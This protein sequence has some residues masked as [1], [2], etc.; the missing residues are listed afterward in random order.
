M[1]PF[2]VRTSPLFLWVTL[3]TSAGCDS[4]DILQRRGPAGVQHHRP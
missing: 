2:C 1:H 4:N 3:V